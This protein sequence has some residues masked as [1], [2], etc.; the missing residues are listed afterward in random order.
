MERVTK[1]KLDISQYLTGI[2][3]IPKITGLNQ[4]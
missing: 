1:K 4:G 2:L 3:S